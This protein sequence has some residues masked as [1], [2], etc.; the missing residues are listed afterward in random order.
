VF[1]GRQE[2]RRGKVREARQQQQQQL[3]L[4]ATTPSSRVDRQSGFTVAVALVHRI[5]RSMDEDKKKKTDTQK[6]VQSTS[7]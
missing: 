1:E 6:E 5:E 4:P 2:G 7:M 3:L